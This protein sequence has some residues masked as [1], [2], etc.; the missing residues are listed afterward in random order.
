MARFCADPGPDHWVAVKRIMKYLKGT[1]DVCI[2]YN[3]QSNIDINGYFRGQLPLAE[4]A[5]MQGS[6][7]SSE[8]QGSNRLTLP[9]G[10]VDADYASDPDSRRSVTGYMFM[11]AGS[12]ISWQSRQQSSVALSTMEAEYMAACS[13]TQ[14]ALYGL[15]CC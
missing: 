4:S 5:R 8:T 11:L 13:A 3:G 10:Y 15:K 6:K 12:P 9:L 7:G 1:I 2:R 14:E